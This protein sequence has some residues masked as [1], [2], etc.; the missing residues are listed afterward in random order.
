MLN[1][2]LTLH[3]LKIKA[4]LILGFE[5][6]ALNMNNICYD[7]LDEMPLDQIIL[8]NSIEYASS[9]PQVLV[10]HCALNTYCDES[11]GIILDTHLVCH[12]F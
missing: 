4:V 6:M 11:L 3:A 9:V 7:S 10:F 2:E 12:K 8:Y 1:Y 5:S